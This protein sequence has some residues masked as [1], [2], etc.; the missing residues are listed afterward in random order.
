MQSQAHDYVVELE[1][2][3]MWETL[4]YKIHVY[5]IQIPIIKFVC[6]ALANIMCKYIQ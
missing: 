4:T 1:C 5:I 6:N 2:L 3:N